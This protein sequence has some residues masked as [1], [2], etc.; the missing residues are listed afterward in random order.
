[1]RIPTSRYR[2]GGDP[3]CRV[4]RLSICFDTDANRHSR[5]PLFVYPDC[6]RRYDVLV[7][8]ASQ[9]RRVAGETDSYLRH[10]V[11]DFPEVK[12]SGVRLEMHE[13]HGARS[14]RV[15]EVRLYRERA[16]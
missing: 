1:V 10:R 16:G 2:R 12:T 3:A 11:L 5:R 14:A 7:E 6:V 13:T 15:Y 9:W 4:H 8:D